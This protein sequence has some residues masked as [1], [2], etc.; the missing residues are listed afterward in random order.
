MGKTSFVLSF[1]VLL[2]STHGIAQQSAAM[3]QDYPIP[4]IGISSTPLYSSWQ[5]QLN[6]PVGL[7]VSLEG[8]PYHSNAGS[9]FVVTTTNDTGAGSLRRAISDANTNPGLDMIAF[10]IQ[11][12]GAKTIVPLSK[13]P[14][15]VDPLTIDGTTQP[16]FVNKPIIEINCSSVGPFQAFDV[17]A[18]GTTIKGL[19]INRLTG[20]TGIVLHPGSNGSVVEGNFFGTDLTG[21]I[22]VGNAYNG[23]ISESSNNRIGGTAPGARNVFVGQGNPPVA[24]ISGAIGNVVQGNLFGTDMTGTVRLG[25]IEDGI[26]IIFGARDDTIGGT[27]AA[28]KNVISGSD[29]FSG[30]AVI[31]TGAAGTQGI[32]IQGNHLG[33]DITGNFDFGNARHGIYIRHSPRNLVGGTNPGARNVISGNTLPGIQ[34]DS[35]G[36][37]QNI[38]QGNT[39]GTRPNGMFALPNSKG[40]V[41]HE[42]PGNLIGGSQTGARNLITGNS[43][44][45]IEIRGVGARGNKVQGN[46]IGTDPLGQA[47]PRNLGHGILINAS[48]DTIGGLTESEGNLIAFNGGAGVFV[49]G[50][51]RNLVL[52]NKIRSNTTLGIDLAPA[53]VTVNDSLDL[54]TGANDLLN[55]PLLDSAIVARDSITIKGWYHGA[56]STFTIH[57]YK[58]STADGSH[59]GEGD[60]SIGTLTV[61]PFMGD[62]S[63]SVTFPVD[64]AGLRFV[65]AVA[66]DPTGNTS[67]FSQALCVTDLDLDGIMDCWETQGWGIDVNSDNVIDMDLYALGARP[68]HKDL[69]VEADAMTGMAP[70]SAAMQKVSNAFAAVPNQYLNNPDGAPGI[71]LHIQLDDTTLGIV[72]WPTNW[73]THFFDIKR[74]TFGTASERSS[75]NKDNILDAK[76]LA[77]RYCIFAYSYDTLGSSGVAEGIGSNDFMVTLGTWS[78]SGGTSDQRAGTFMHELGHTLGLRHGGADDENYKPNYISIMS[79]T[80]QTPFRWADTWRLDYSRTALP[81]LDE[82]RLL[83][84]SGLGSPMGFTPIINVPFSGPGRVKRYATTRHAAAVDWDTSGTTNSGPVAVDVNVF[85]TNLDPSPGDTLTSQSDWPLLIYNFRHTAGF[86]DGP[87]AKQVLETPEMTYRDFLDLDSLPPPKPKHFLMDGQLDAEVVRITSGN[88]IAL[89][90][91]FREGE[92]YVATN[93]AQSQNADMFVFVTADNENPGVPPPWLKSGQVAAWDAFLANE[94]TNNSVGWYDANGILKQNNAIG[95][96]GPSVLE[97]VIDLGLVVGVEPSRFV[98]AVGKYETNDGGLLLAQAPPG[99]GDGDI[100]AGGELYSYIP[101]QPRYWYQTAGPM[102]ENVFSLYATGPDEIYAG[103]RRGGFKTTD[104]GDS[105]THMT[106]GLPQVRTFDFVRTSDGNLYAASDSGVFLS[107]NSG[108]TWQSRSSGLTNL[109]SRAVIAS[110]QG[111]LLA[112]TFSGGF[113]STDHGASW[114]LMGGGLPA[115]SIRAFAIDS[116]GHILAGSSAGGLFRS[117]DNGITWEPTGM[118]EPNVISITLDRQGRIYYVKS[119]PSIVYRS[120]DGGSNW[121]N[122]LQTSMSTQ[123]MGV[124]QAGK[125]YAATAEGVLQSTDDGATWNDITDGVPGQSTWSLVVTSNDNVY[126]GTF[127]AGVCRRLPTTVTSVRSTMNEIPMEV[128]LEQNYPNPF[129]TSTHIAFTIPARMQTGGPVSGFTT[130]KVFD[131]LGREV[132]TLVHEVLDAGVHQV[133]WDAS[134]VAS[135]VYIARL[136]A[137]GFTSAKKMLLIR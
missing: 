95:I 116:S 41:L 45:G 107:T 35:A 118:S 121:A 31:G 89:Y 70:S 21:T 66:T 113:R 136:Q 100:E 69:F 124:D 17:F 54:D 125:I 93:S 32:V 106:S 2:A 130:L 127:N 28:A 90:A 123:E 39:I 49:A 5:S 6:M 60:S 104:G 57:F 22:R 135:G 115:S 8:T 50:G 110:P 99:D 112:G 58:N 27:S 128:V 43:D 26:L 67:E 24:L 38:I 14:N 18:P 71:N 65:T 98:L 131:V 9:V 83:E 55:F 102:S 4:G 87:P 61:S 48:Q 76:R 97:G 11:P 88:G 53:G 16:G 86:I 91:A 56:D 52:K 37:T 134:G 126:V 77:F 13:L 92:L 119:S 117:T 101:N 73:W 108:V 46:Y 3:L 33:T 36:A 109:E 19:V 40:I 74:D 122:I 20:G 29:N 10:N 42:S 94:S 1:L 80:W 133:Q 25:N 47:G 72:A 64:T 30:I 68:D 59:F 103:A 75:P 7:R 12:L 137:G 78:T 105:W 111:A 44:V 81:S 132:A 51:S 15:I 84:A 96:A 82:S 23:V 79:Y 63:F 62:K 85:R 129:N 120:S 114:T 34:I